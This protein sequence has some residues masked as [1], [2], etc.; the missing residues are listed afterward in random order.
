MAPKR[1]EKQKRRSID[2]DPFW[3]TWEEPSPSPVARRRP[4]PSKHRKKFKQLKG[5]VDDPFGFD[6]FGDTWEKKPARRIA[7]RNSSL[8]PVVLPEELIALEDAPDGSD[9][10]CSSSAVR[11]KSWDAVEHLKAHNSK[12]ASMDAEYK[13]KTELEAKKKAEK[14]AA[15]AEAKATK[16]TAKAEWDRRVELAKDCVARGDPAVA[17]SML[18]SLSRDSAVVH[19]I[20]E[21]AKKELSELYSGL[22]THWELQ[23]MLS[24]GLEPCSYGEQEESNLE[25]STCNGGDTVKVN[26]STLEQEESSEIAT[27]NSTVVVDRLDRLPAAC[28]SGQQSTSTNNSDESCSDD[29]GGDTVK[30]NRSTEEESDSS[31]KT[32]AVLDSEGRLLN[33]FSSKESPTQRNSQWELGG[34]TNSP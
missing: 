2:D 32:A 5:S 1:L 33:R 25:S 9:S 18:Q 29:T 8:E 21:E 31:T 22:N 13:E 28:L 34:G 23:Q 4:K 7:R 19:H 30:V 16:A 11:K 24:R 14:E 26:R 12:M 20:N 10:W 3:D 15:E 17:I 27:G 6:G